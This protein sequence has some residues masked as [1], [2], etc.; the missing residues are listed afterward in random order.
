MSNLKSSLAR[1]LTTVTSVATI[2]WSVGLFSAAPV[3]AATLN[4]GDLVKA[5]GSSAVYLIQGTTK[6]VFPHLNVYL[7]WGFPSNF[8]TVKAV[9]MADLA[10]YT[11]GDPVPFRDGYMFR[12]TASGLGGRSAT[13]VYVVANGLRRAVKSA[14][15]YQALYN[16]P[17]W[18]RVTWV[19]DDLLT[20]FNY[21]EGAVVESTTS[22]PDGTLVK[23]AGADQVYLLSGGKKRALGTGALAANRYNAA[24]VVTLAASETYADD[25][26]VSGY[27]VALSLPAAPAGSGSVATTVTGQVTVSLSSM[28]PSASSLPMGAMYA[29]VMYVDVMN[30]T[31]TEVKVT[32]LT[33]TRYG[34]MADRDIDGVLVTDSD[35]ITHGNL[36]TFGQSVSSPGFA[37]NPIK[38]AAGATARVNVNVNLVASA[39]ASATSNTLGVSLA[40]P[41]AVTVTDGSGNPVS[42][43]GTFPVKGPLMGTV[44]GAGSLGGVTVTAQNVNGGT[45]A[46]PTNIDQGTKDYDSGKFRFQETTGNE[47]VELLN[48]TLQN[49]GSASASDFFNIR[50]VDQEGNVV[51][52]TDAVSANQAKFAVRGTGANRGPAGGYLIK[53]GQLRDFVVRIDTSATSNSGGRTVN[54]TLQNTYDVRAVGLETGV[55]V[56]I[57]ATTP[58][59]S[60]TNTISFRTGSLSISRSTDSLSGKIAPGA[61]DLEVATFDVRA[62]GEDIEL[63]D[64]GFVIAASGTAGITLNNRVPTGT[65]KVKNEAGQTVYSITSSTTALYGT[66]CTGGG[67]LAVT[68]GLIA[69]C[70][71]AANGTGPSASSSTTKLNNTYVVKAGTTGKL[72]FVMDISQSATSSDSYLVNVTYLKFRRLS[73]NILAESTSAVAGNSLSVESTVLT[74]TANTS[75]NPQTLV[76]G[77]SLQKIGSFNLQAGAAESQTVTSITGK[78]CIDD[79]ATAFAVADCS[80]GLAAADY[81]TQVAFLSNVE[82]REGTTRLAPA[83]NITTTAGATYSLQGFTIPA[84]QTRV[85]DVYAVVSTSFN[86]GATDRLGTTLTINSSV[87]GQSQSSNA[88]AERAGQSITFSDAGTLTVSTLGTDG[89]INTNKVLHASESDVPLFKF[90]IRESSNAE[91]LTIQK[92]YLGVEAAQN[93]LTDYKLFDADTNAQLGVTAPANIAGTTTS[94]EVRFTGLNYQVPKGGTKNLLVKASTVDGGTM[95]VNS[96]VTLG[97][98]FMEFVGQSS[99]TTT[100]DS[101]GIVTDSS[102]ANDTITVNDG[103]QFEV[104]DSV[105]IDANANGAFS[106][107]TGGVTET[108]S[109]CVRSVSSNTVTLSATL[110]CTG[111]SGILDITA[112]LTAGGRVAPVNSAFSSQNAHVEE[113]EPVISALQVGAGNQ[114]SENPLGVFVVSAQGSQPLTVSSLRFEV[115]GSYNTT[116]TATVRGF[117]PM[118]FKLDRANPTT[119]ERDQDTA[120]NTLTPYAAYAGTNSAGTAIAN[121]GRLVNGALSL[122]ATS[123][124]FDTGVAANVPVGTRVVFG[125]ETNGAIGYR[126]T[127]YTTNGA[128]DATGTFTISPALQAAVADNVAITFA[129]TTGTGNIC[130]T[131]VEAICKARS[132]S[133]TAIFESGA[134]VGFDLSTADTIGVGSSKGYMLLADSTRIKDNT[135]SG[136]TASSTVR[137]LGNRADK[138]TDTSLNATNGLHWNYTRTTGAAASASAHTISDSYIVTG[139]TILYL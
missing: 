6:R 74:V 120:L 48:L 20:K 13:A 62:F 90:Q 68:S 32:G 86:P 57:T 96:N 1:A 8:S 37:T 35:G 15:V 9:S 56:A 123:V 77:G 122:A 11:E 130:G 51:G 71:T 66:G 93:T 100:R 69:G 52:Q 83:A 31:N 64:V 114:V 21:A 47:H 115:S 119:G 22:H 33:V 105:R 59:G 106:G 7:S 98:T 117:S 50:I 126:V 28:Q 94:G 46:S 58:V 75:F 112:A 19:P 43:G 79:A 36:T 124:T 14:E 10:Q 17:N 3:Q 99:G 113:V 138:D 23:Y 55:G 80:T 45:T 38:V 129:G 76:K 44:S 81:T 136:S 63:Q 108:T 133:G 88:V 101:G 118:S 60:S 29:P 131:T 40:G 73:S 91:A 12:G 128:T 2:L 95:S 65:V 137:L 89:T 49:I 78:L 82:L 70:G 85:V 53:E 103:S 67:T 97:A 92:L 116:S 135:T 30:G 24:L 102:A 54:W 16:D 139:K 25:S 26:A 134:V 127:G 109:Y 41:S 27:E 34:I 107:T 87:G 125:T 121:G 61:T 42:V 132:P 39:S 84:N 4:N 110:S 5:A 72:R 104:G 111:A 18:A